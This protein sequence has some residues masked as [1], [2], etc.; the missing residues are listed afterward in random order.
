[1]I[2]ADRR[3]LDIRSDVTLS[4]GSQRIGHLRG[5]GHDLVLDLDRLAD[6]R[7]LSRFRS[8]DT[9][10]LLQAA[11]LDFQIQVR[12]R[13]VATFRSA[14]VN[15]P[16]ATTDQHPGVR[17]RPMAIVRSALGRLAGRP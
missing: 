9:T 10:D 12:G 7:T 1:M 14:A 5:D 11:S 6:L 16:G 15:A 13:T 4:R 2:R 3:P 17:I 8:G